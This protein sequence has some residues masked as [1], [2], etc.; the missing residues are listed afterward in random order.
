MR[1][2]GVYRNGVLAGTLTEENRNSYIFKY[3]NNYYS[4]SSKPAVS[5]TLPKTN[6]IYK[7]NNLFPFFYNMI[8]EGV[9]KKLQCTR[10]KIDE[11][12][13]FGL[14]LAIAQYDTIGAITIKPIEI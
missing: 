6:Q 7:S 12:D 13:N 2:A 14:L 9:N 11:N 8:S 3:D 4:D 1:I 5:L 10:L